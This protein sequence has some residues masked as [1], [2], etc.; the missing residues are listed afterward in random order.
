MAGVT[1]F[2]GH[3]SPDHVACVNTFT[4]APMDRRREFTGQGVLTMYA[5][6]DQTDIDLFVRVSLVFGGHDAGLPIKVTPGMAARIAPRAGPISTERK[7]PPTPTTTTA[8][9]PRRSDCTNVPRG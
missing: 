4:M 1:V 3:G 9:I 7:S 8:S 2:D 5:S 6:T